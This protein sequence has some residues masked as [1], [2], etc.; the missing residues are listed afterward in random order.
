MEFSVAMSELMNAIIKLHNEQLKELWDLYKKSENMADLISAVSAVMSAFVA[1][2]ALFV[3]HRSVL[4]ARQ[5]AE[6]QMQHNQLSVRPVPEIV[7]GDYENRLFVKLRNHGTGPLTV[8]RFIVGYKGELSESLIDCMPQMGG[9]G[10]TKFCGNIDNRTIPPDGELELL[11][12]DIDDMDHG[13]V[14]FRD[15]VRRALSNS[16]PKV[17]YTDIYRNTFPEY[18]R[19]LAWFNRHLVD[20]KDQSK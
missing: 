9:Y 19:S 7:F 4:I 12:L 18:S 5:T 3:S 20:E 1:A 17:T 13:Q 15:E 16:E 6:S 10:W 8:S 2:L 11:Q 14:A